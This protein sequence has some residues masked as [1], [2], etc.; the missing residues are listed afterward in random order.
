MLFSKINYNVLFR[1]I[2]IR[3]RFR[4]TILR[5]LN[6]NYYDENDFNEISKL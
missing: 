1:L 2:E 4:C 6:M 3:F 5:S